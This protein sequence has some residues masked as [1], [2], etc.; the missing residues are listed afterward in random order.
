MLLTF[1]VTCEGH[2]GLPLTYTNILTDPLV[3]QL[4]F[5]GSS[6]CVMSPCCQPSAYSRSKKICPAV[7]TQHFLCLLLLHWFSSSP[8]PSL[9][10]SLFWQS[11]SK[12]CTL[13][14]WLKTQSLKCSHY[15]KEA[16]F[17]KNLKFERAR[18]FIHGQW[19]RLNRV[20]LSFPH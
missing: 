5:G 12:L 20:T 18:M 3:F 10:L 2:H 4:Y 7:S 17:R 15:V 9:V 11:F 6:L 8:P 16:N 19:R 14:N 13:I 1:A